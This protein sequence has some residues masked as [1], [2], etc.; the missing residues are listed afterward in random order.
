MEWKRMS[1]TSTISSCSISKVLARGSWASWSRPPKTSSYIRATRSGVSS[2]P[3]RS[4]SS[5]IAARISRTAPATR[6]WSTGI[7]GLRPHT[8]AAIVG[9]RCAGD[10]RAL[11]A[12]VRQ[13]GRIRLQ[14]FARVGLLGAGGAGGRPDPRRLER[15]PLGAGLPDLAQRALGDIGEDLAELALVQRLLLQQLGDQP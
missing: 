2:R 4:G 12:G 7:S 6:C 15:R 13:L 1:R 14:R 5:P 9:A 10:V 11:P 8:G 3:S